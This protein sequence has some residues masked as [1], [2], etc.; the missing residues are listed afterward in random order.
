MKNFVIFGV[1]GDLSRRYILP[2]LNCLAG[3][4]HKFRY[5]GFSRSP[6]TPPASDIFSPQINLFQG[7]Y[8]YSGLTRLASKLTPATIFYFALPTN[9]QLIVS[10]VSALLA[11]HLID[12]RT[13]LVIEKPFGSDYF[14][15]QKLMHYL[16][17]SVGQDQI[18]LVDHYLTKEL[19]RN[20]VSLRF[21]NPIVSRLWNRHHIAEINIIAIESEGIGTRGGYYDQIGAVRDM[22]QNH[23]LQLLALTTMSPPLSFDT[24]DFIKQKLNVINHLHLQDESSK[25][26][27]VGQYR[28]YLRET[29]VS[30]QS[31]TETFAQ[32]KFRLDLPE[33]AKVPLTITTGKKLDQKLTEINIIFQSDPPTGLWKDHHRLDPNV[34]SIQLS[35]HPDIFLSLNSSFQPNFQLPHPQNLHLGSLSLHP[36]SAYENVILDILNGVKI[37]TPSFAEILSQWKI[38]DHILSLPRLRSTLFCY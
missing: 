13:R 18:F 10:L 30:P 22:V 20:L 3:Q 34:L 25:S 24:A 1:S 28:G 26:V 27:Q 7:S 4:G 35:P 17:Q 19:V 8:D 32:I 33:W 2:A 36:S 15:A 23:C 12:S 37:N 9:Y 31:Q 38:V 21:A 11:H 16:D 5:F 14:S 29:G 6:V